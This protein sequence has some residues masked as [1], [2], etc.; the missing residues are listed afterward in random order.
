[1]LMTLPQVGC[2]V[3]YSRIAAVDR[4]SARGSPDV[5]GLVAVSERAVRQLGFKGSENHYLDSGMTI[6][7]LQDDRTWLNVVINDE[8]LA[9][10]LTWDW[11]SARF[12]SRVQSAIEREF[13]ATYDSHLQFK[14]RPCG[15][16]GP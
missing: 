3:S 16:F 4:T 2:C 14:D 13:A 8:T 9:I 7:A 1:M 5:A 6:Y 12:A 15:W 10:G 11:R